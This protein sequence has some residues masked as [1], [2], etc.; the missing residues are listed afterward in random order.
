LYAHRKGHKIFLGSHKNKI[1]NNKQTQQLSTTRMSKLLILAL[2]LTSD[3][4]FTA[5][6][7]PLSMGRYPVHSTKASLATFGAI[8]AQQDTFGGSSNTE[9]LAEF[10]PDGFV[11]SIEFPAPLNKVDRFKRAGTFWLSAAPILMK[12]YGVL[13]VMKLREMH[14]LEMSETEIEVCHSFMVPQVMGDT[15]SVKF[16]LSCLLS[17]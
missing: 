12:N 15:Y 5:G 14:G 3:G 7:R 10:S 16:S 1:T 9:L 2:A 8:V 6:F 13:A 11:G 4:L 17:S